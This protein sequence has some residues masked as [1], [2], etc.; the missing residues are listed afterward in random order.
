[1]SDPLEEMRSERD[2]FAFENAELRSQVGHLK[3]QV[4][5]EQEA[6][7]EALRKLEATSTAWSATFKTKDALALIASEDDVLKAVRTHL[8]TLTDEEREKFFYEVERGYCGACGRALD[9][10][11][12]MGCQCTNDE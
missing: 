11:S 5:G 10:D 9:A 12:L 8:P 4:R 2:R 3:T 7:E 1:M 6:K